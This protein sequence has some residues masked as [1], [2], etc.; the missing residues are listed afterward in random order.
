MDYDD[1][2]GKE[3]ETMPL[4]LERR[5][6]CMGG[7]AVGGDGAVASRRS[8]KKAGR[9]PVKG[10]ESLRKAGT[11]KSSKK[12]PSLTLLIVEIGLPS[13][14]MSLMAAFVVAQAKT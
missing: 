13:M 12:E 2:K 5:H 4:K 10:G 8:Q 6:C 3:E 7:E 11:L 1:G 14:S 9:V